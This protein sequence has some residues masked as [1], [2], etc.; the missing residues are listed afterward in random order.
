[1]KCFG[2]TSL[3]VLGV[4]GQYDWTCNHWSRFTID[5]CYQ[6]STTYQ[7]LLECNTTDSLILSQYTDGSCGETDADPY[8]EIAYWEISD[9]TNLWQCDQSAPC[10]YAILRYYTDE[11]CSGDTYSD[12]PFITGQCYSD[13]STSF[14]VSCSSDTLTVK[15]YT[16]Q[17][18]CTGSSVSVTVDYA[19]YNDDVTGCY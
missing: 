14:E 16:S 12:D 8:V 17:G 15:T 18:D 13:T 9:T 7:Y 1:M 6:Y 2:L 19:D 3:L 10:D 11:D 5:Y 4:S